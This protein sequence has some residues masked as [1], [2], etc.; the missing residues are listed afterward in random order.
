MEGD[1]RGLLLPTYQ[2]AA[3]MPEKSNDLRK[4]LAARQALSAAAPQ[5][6]TILP[7]PSQTSSGAHILW[8]AG[9]CCLAA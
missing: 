1:E 8:R 2:E 6:P 4:K 5:V 9:A 3:E 7:S